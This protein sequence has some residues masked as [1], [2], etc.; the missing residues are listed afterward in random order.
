MVS[1][2]HCESFQ[3]G[4]LGHGGSEQ[5]RPIVHIPL[6]VHLPGQQLRHAIVAAVDQ[7]AFAPTILEIAG[8]GR[9]DWMDGRSLLAL[10]GAAGSNQTPRAFTQ[11]L[12]L[13]SSFTPVTRGTIGVIDGLHQFVL[14]LEKNAG[15][16]FNLAE[17]HEQKFDRSPA[18]P[19]LAADL[20]VQI[21]RRF[22]E[23]LG[24]RRDQA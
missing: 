24:R 9:P 11:Y 20:R 23:V 7:T 6:V 10:T 17:A 15:A 1:A 2:D 12:A 13:N 3:G 5:L 19:A 21:V 18:V 14:D 16:L 22:P 4:F 8:L